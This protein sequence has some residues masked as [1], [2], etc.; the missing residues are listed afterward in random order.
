MSS[1]C[2]S[3]P[4]GLNPYG[5]DWKV[6]GSTMR[7]VKDEIILFGPWGDFQAFA[8]WIVGEKLRIDNLY[9]SSLRERRNGSVKP[10]IK[11]FFGLYISAEY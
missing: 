5:Y 9:V 3:K 7:F 6:D 11:S 8:D 10:G 2:S 1:S 4:G